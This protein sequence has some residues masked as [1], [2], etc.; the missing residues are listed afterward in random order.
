[1]DSAMRWRLRA[2]ILLA[3]L[4]PAGH[5]AQ[6]I[7]IAGQ[8]LRDDTGAPVP[9]AEVLAPAMPLAEAVARIAAAR[10]PGPRPAPVYLRAA[11]A[12]PPTDP[13]PLILP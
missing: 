10:A 6:T 7:T 3:L 13:P 2:L 12:L 4:L 5:V 8:V 11:D 9:G 1:H